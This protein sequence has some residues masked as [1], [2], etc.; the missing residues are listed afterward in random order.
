MPGWGHQLCFGRVL[1]EMRDAGLTA[2]ELGPRGFLPADNAELTAVLNTHGLRGV[3]TFVPVVLHDPSRDP[4][5]DVVGTLGLLAACGAE[6]LVVAAATGANGYDG[7]RTLDDTGWAT[8]FNNLERLTEV[9]TRH[10]VVAVLHPHVGTMVET[11]ADVD[12]V[13]SGSSMR[14]CLDTGHLLIG[15]TDPVE[16]ARTAP[17]RVGHVHLKDV[18]AGLAARVRSGELTYTRAVAQGM[19][20][21]LGRGDVGI[22]EIVSALRHIGFDGWFVLEQDTVLDGD[23]VDGGPL[24]DVSASLGYLQSVLGGTRLAEEPFSGTRLAE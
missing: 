7:R 5:A 8:L 12:R 23:P 20:R 21:P 19:Y 14:L 10:G 1:R 6:V 4:V 15:G 13:L 9:A 16:V 17:N 2:T 24:R 18:D 11:R 3:G 22:D